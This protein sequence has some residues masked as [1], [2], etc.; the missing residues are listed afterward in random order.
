MFWNLFYFIVEIFVLGFFM[1]SYFCI[2]VVFDGNNNFVFFFF[3]VD[4]DIDIIYVNSKFNIVG[5]VFYMWID[6]KLKFL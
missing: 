3:G 6:I 1:L 5:I 4:Y 2:I